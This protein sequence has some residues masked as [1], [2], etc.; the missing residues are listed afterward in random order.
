MHRLREYES[1]YLSVGLEDGK[2]P[3]HMNAQ[4]CIE[5]YEGSGQFGQLPSSAS[6]LSP[7]VGQISVPDT[8]AQT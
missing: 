4:F 8:V 5:I 2:R 7:A 3:A 1:P 6:S